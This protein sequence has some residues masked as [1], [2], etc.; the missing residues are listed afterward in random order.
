ME[1]ATFNAT[2]NKMLLKQPKEIQEAV[3]KNIQ[4]VLE[5]LEQETMSKE[6]IANV[7]FHTKQGY[8]KWWS[9]LQ[10]LIQKSLYQS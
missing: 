8:N 1:I 4:I 6:A 9:K 5:L 10:K 2:I 7:I 3:R